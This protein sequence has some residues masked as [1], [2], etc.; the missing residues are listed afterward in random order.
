MEKDD[1]SFSFL[2]SLPAGG[3]WDWLLAF[4][5]HRNDTHKATKDW[6]ERGLYF[7]QGADRQCKANVVL[8]VFNRSLVPHGDAVE[9]SEMDWVA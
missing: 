6:G 5:S 1:T 4:A 2:L 3:G 7:L 9:G 8:L